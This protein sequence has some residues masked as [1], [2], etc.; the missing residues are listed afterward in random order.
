MTFALTQYACVGYKEKY[1][2]RLKLRKI[3]QN[4]CHKPNSKDDS[5]IK[6]FLTK[7]DIMD[8]GIY[9]GFV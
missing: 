9:F 8:A 1:Y 6:I 5:P 4:A 7:R 2:L 3:L